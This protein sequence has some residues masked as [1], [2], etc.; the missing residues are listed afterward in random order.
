MNIK[1]LID[2]EIFSVTKRNTKVFDEN[3]KTLKK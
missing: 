1:V 3:I 2:F